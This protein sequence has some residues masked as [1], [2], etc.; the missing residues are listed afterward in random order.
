MG[1]AEAQ[2]LPLNRSEQAVSRFLMRTSTWEKPARDR[3]SAD[4][5]N[6]APLRVCGRERCSP[7][8]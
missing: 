7:P 1:L 6:W 8:H 3:Y 5:Q 2:Q 4:R